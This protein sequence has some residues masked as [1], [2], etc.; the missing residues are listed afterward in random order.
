MYVCNGILEGIFFTVILPY[1]F[2]FWPESFSV[3]VIVAVL[4]AIAVRELPAHSYFSGRLEQ[5]TVCIA[6]A[7]LLIA[8][9]LS[10][11]FRSSFTCSVGVWN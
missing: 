2:I 6:A 7:S 4:V 10:F 9:V 5:L 1:M 8:N 11:M 3:F